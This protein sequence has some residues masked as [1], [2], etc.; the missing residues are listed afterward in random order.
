M[1]GTWQVRS[2]QA[3]AG[4]RSGIGRVKASFYGCEGCGIF[5]DRGA[6]M[7]CGCGR[8]TCIPTQ[9]PVRRLV[10][11]VIQACLDSSSLQCKM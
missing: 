1:L 8:S 9:V 2:G 6:V 7:G 3:K 10:K 5:A 11:E 4:T